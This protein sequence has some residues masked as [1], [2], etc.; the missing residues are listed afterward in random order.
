MPNMIALYKYFNISSI[1]VVSALC[2]TSCA[3]IGSPTGGP[4][5]QK[6]PKVTESKPKTG[7]T[8]FTGDKIEITFDEYIQLS[9]IY[10]QLVISPPVEEKPYVRTR[11]KSVIIELKNELDSNTTYTISFGDAI[12]DNNEKNI[13]SNYRF[14]LSTGSYLDSMSVSGTVIDAR[15]LGKIEEPVYIGLYDNLNDSAPLIQAPVYV[16]KTNDNGGYEIS[17]V[18][19]GNYRIFALSDVNANLIYDM[20]DEKIAFADTAVPLFSA[21]VPTDNFIIEDST[22][23]HQIFDSLQADSTRNVDSLLMATSATRKMY[24]YH[25]NLS[26]FQEDNKKQYLANYNR[27]SK[28]RLNFMFN[29]GLDDFIQLTP[30]NIVSNDN[31][32]YKEFSKNRDTLIVWLN[33]SNIY[34][35][36]SLEIH[37]QYHIKD[38]LNKLVVKDDTLLFRHSEE[39]K[40]T[41]RGKSKDEVTEKIE[42][43]IP[44]QINSNVKSG[45]RFDLDKTGILFFETPVF[46]WNPAKIELYALEDTI[47]KE[48]KFEILKD[49]TRLNRFI[50]KTNWKESVSYKLMIIDSAFT[51][52][53]G[54]YNDSTEFKF[55][56]Q[57]E[58]YYGILSFNISGIDSPTIIQLLDKDDKLV[59]E[60]H[61]SDNAL[62]RFDY[63]PAKE[64]KLRAILDS[65]NNDKWDTG[66]YLKKIQPEKVINYGQ[67]INVRSNWEIE[68]QWH[69]SR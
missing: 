41:K 14:V 16:S 7:S 48:Q 2:I 52:I 46:T 25:I 23:Y 49:T 55:A 56:T 34:N 9:D 57:R 65:N 45:G 66:N 26:L 1:L 19:P 40:K 68:Q 11:G 6:P 15:N 27:A 47:Y 69:L 59:R 21:S 42:Q 28:Y 3:K 35:N 18:R 8:S 44:L 13:L 24:G 4:V 33:D 50:L 54:F 60:H 37:L 43:R 51:D 17:H 31:W 58:D 53:Y 20:A 32:S 38:S 39:S 36:D 64:Y 62:L 10:S 5:D 12:A 61:I 30:L 22:L 63:I 29:R 67:V